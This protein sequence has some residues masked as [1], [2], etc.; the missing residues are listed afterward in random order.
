M[1]RF[2]LTATL[3]ALVAAPGVATAAT[4]N[5]PPGNSGLSQYLEVVPTAG[6]GKPSRNAGA[7]KPNLPAR[8]TGTLT[9]QGADG[10][11]LLRV[12]AGTSPDAPKHKAK[13]AKR[14]PVTPKRVTATRDREHGALATA[15]TGGGGG[16]GDGG[17]GVPLLVPML[18]AAGLVGAFAVGRR[19]SGH[20]A[21]SE[22]EPDA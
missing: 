14:K 15:F 4:T 22:P 18:I 1:R 13:H 20:N 16:R 21:S 2:L 10:Q 3:L 6:G 11:Q 12:V 7:G 8:Q 5:S 9:R 17:L 19:F